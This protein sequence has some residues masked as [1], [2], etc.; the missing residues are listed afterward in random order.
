MIRRL[1][2][3]LNTPALDIIDAPSIVLAE[4]NGAPQRVGFRYHPDYLASIKT[5]NET[6]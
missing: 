5:H 6:Q 3:Y 4:D 2:R 1:G